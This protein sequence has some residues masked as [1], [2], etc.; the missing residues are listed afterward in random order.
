MKDQKTHEPNELEPK[1]KEV[2]ETPAVT[3]QDADDDNGLP[4]DPSKPRP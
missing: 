2:K 1:D 4:T 3:T